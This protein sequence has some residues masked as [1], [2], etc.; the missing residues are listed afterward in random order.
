MKNQVVLALSATMFFFEYSGS[1]AGDF[2][3]L[4]ET[5]WVL[6]AGDTVSYL[7]DVENPCGCLDPLAAWSLKLHLDPA[8][9]ASGTV[10]FQSIS[11]PSENYLLEGRSLYFGPPF[12][13]PSDTIDLIG[14][15][16]NQLTGVEVPATRKS[17]LEVELTASA[18]AQGLF[19]ID[20]LPE[21]G[22]TTYWLYMDPSSGDPLFREFDNIPFESS[23]VTIGS[24]LV[25]PVADTHWTGG[26]SSNWSD[27]SNW[28]AGSPG[29]GSIIQFD[30]SS[31]SY[32]PTLQDIANPL[33]LAGIAFTGEASEHTLDGQALQFT[34][35]APAVS[36][37]SVNYQSINNPLV[38]SVDTV[39]FVSGLGSLTLGGEVSGSGMFVKSGPGTLVLASN[40]SYGG[41]TLIESGLFTLDTTGQI[42]NSTI[43]NDATFQILD[44]NHSVSAINGIGT[45]EVLLGSLTACSI[46]Q[47]TLIIGTEASAAIPPLAGESVQ[48]V[49]EPASI[50]LL[51]M[52]LLSLLGGYF[53]CR[54]WK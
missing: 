49:P 51:T 37:T 36:C 42:Q 41:E 54:E 20:V 9:T 50:G 7:V 30:A 11:P 31:L 15:T 17:L 32:Q 26:N 35:S 38:L 25:Q 39:F 48:P 1:R 14:D 23:S 29:S 10:V 12:S 13:G 45:T 24:V 34:G 52:A 16:D 53:A 27:S 43:T 5:D 4:G 21:G 47:D 3:V 8:V 46:I 33:S 6:T 18:D 22:T 2:F 44:G 40:G 28:T 19:T